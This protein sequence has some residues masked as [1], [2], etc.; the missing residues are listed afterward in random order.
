[1]TEPAGAVAPPATDDDIYWRAPC[2]YHP[3]SGRLEQQALLHERAHPAAVPVNT[4][5]RR[6]RETEQHYK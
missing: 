4:Q 3:G 2:A 6:K 1:M 5:R